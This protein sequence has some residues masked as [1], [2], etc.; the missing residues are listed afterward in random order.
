MKREIKAEIVA[1]SKNEYGQ[2][3][4]TFIL[5]YP[6]FIHAELLTHRL[7][8]R[9]AASSRAIPAKKMI[10]AIVNDPFV[11]VAWQKAHKG[12]QGTEYFDYTE[13]LRESWVDASLSAVDAAEVLMESGVTKQLINRLLEPFQWYTCLVTATEYDNFFELRC[14]QY[15]VDGKR[16]KHYKSRK[17]AIRD[18]STLSKYDLLSWLKSN[19]AQGEIHISLLAEAMWDARNESTPKQ[20]KAGEWH[21]PFGDRFDINRVED[22]S[23][24]TLFTREQLKVK[25][26]TAR[27]ARISY[28]NF[29]GKDDYE[30]D[31]D[32]Y[33]SL[34]TRPYTNK[35]GFTFT[36]KDP[37]HMSP[38]EHCARAMSDNDRFKEAKDEFNNY[39]RV[40]NEWSG[41]FR[42]FVQLRKEIE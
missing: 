25:I 31:I 37:K 19:H 15:E 30:A 34:L 10:E 2:R 35:K 4:T 23:R 42:G 14:P 17:D 27:C 8:S 32:L 7:F 16:D 18:D 21:I 26:A 24:D 3:I 12:M 33:N 5:T 28:N 38:S 6:R 29:E 40:E 1:D 20:L 22:L 13:T 36:E 11:P 39:I 9:N 41:N